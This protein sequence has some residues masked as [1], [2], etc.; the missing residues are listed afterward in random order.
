[1]FVSHAYG[2]FGHTENAYMSYIDRPTYL[3]IFE[4][5]GEN[6]VFRTATHFSPPTIVDEDQ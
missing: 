2:V 3:H 1:M 6:V 4:T 5:K